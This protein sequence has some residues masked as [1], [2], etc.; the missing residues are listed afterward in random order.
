MP[1]QIRGVLILTYFISDYTISLRNW[2]DNTRIKDWLRVF[3]TE[4]ICR[5]AVACAYGAIDRWPMGLRVTASV[6]GTID[7]CKES[8]TLYG[9]REVV[10]LTLYSRR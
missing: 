3:G 9:V 2:C 4:R 10:W 6:V 5:Q 1:L 8:A 7:N